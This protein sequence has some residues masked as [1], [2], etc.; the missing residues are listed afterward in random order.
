MPRCSTLD[1][2]WLYA[3]RSQGLTPLQPSQTVVRG[4]EQVQHW[5]ALTRNLCNTE[6]WMGSWGPL[7]NQVQ[8]FHNN[9]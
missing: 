9:R 6:A 3:T 8:E 7:S 4:A 1:T 2:P 5:E